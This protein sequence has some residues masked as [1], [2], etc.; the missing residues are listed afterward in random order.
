MGR[1]SLILI[2]NCANPNAV[3][4][5]IGDAEEK[6]F[7]VRTIAKII[8]EHICDLCGE[9]LVCFPDITT[10]GNEGLKVEG[11]FNSDLTPA[12]FPEP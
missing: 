5:S 8:R 6:R 9:L 10:Y 12:N 7:E 11:H 4:R 2:E 3:A 1:L